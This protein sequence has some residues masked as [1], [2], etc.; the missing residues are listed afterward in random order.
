MATK[1]GGL[2]STPKQEQVIQDELPVRIRFLETCVSCVRP[3]LPPF[4]IPTAHPRSQVHTSSQSE[5]RTAR[6]PKVIDM[7]ALVAV[8]FEGIVLLIKP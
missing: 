1:E 2:A 8:D 6:N 4:H 5:R 7:H 3:V